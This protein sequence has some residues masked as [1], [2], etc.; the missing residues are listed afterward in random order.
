MMTK[1]QSKRKP[2]TEQRRSRLKP[3][4]PEL[5][6]YDKPPE[7]PLSR[8]RDLDTIPLRDLPA[9][10]VDPAAGPHF[11]LCPD[12][13]CFKPKHHGGVCQRFPQPLTKLASDGCWDGV[14]LPA[15]EEEGD[16]RITE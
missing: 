4:S 16:E 9:G 12:C 2:S 13:G 1:P 15:P 3:G 6:A 5:A 8:E 7:H 11:R 10:S 14:P